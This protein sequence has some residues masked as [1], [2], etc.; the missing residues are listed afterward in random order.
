MSSISLHRWV[1]V[2]M[3]AAAVVLVAPAAYAAAPP[4]VG[5]VYTKANGNTTTNG[6][7]TVIVSLDLP[8]GKYHV[9]GRG[10]LNNQTLATDTVSCNVY[11]GAGNFVDANT[12]T[13]PSGGYEALAYEGVATVPS[14]GAALW[15]ECIANQNPGP[16]TSARLVA[17]VVPTIVEVP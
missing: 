10:T 17:T 3:G 8:A 1:A 15:V 6:V 14:G 11:V 4:K 9:S 2:A 5:T 16:F 13:V 12:A 7:Y